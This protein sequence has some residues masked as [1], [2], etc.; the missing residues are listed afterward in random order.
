MDRADG[1]VEE[2]LPCVFHFAFLMPNNYDEIPLFAMIEIISQLWVGRHRCM[3][4]GWYFSTGWSW[5]YSRCFDRCFDHCQ[6][7][8]WPSNAKCATR[9]AICGKSDHSGCGSLYWC[10]LQD[11]SQIRIHLNRRFWKLYE[12]TI[13]F[14]AWKFN[15]I[16]FW[17]VPFLGNLFSLQRIG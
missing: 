12:S 4:F 10:F 5:H 2:P 1:R 11:A 6:P 8:Y 9:M 14:V 16:I 7:D 3:H 15:C 17:I 13:V